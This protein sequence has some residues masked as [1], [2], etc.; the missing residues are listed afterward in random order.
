MIHRKCYE[1]HRLVVLR[2]FRGGSPTFLVPLGPGGGERD[3]PNVVPGL[4]SLD[5]PSGG[6]GLLLSD[7]VHGATGLRDEI[8]LTLCHQSLQALQHH[9]QSVMS[10]F[11]PINVGGSLKGRFF[12]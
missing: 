10:V 2:L 8:L 12:L 6:C 11:S 1:Q 4:G 7:V 9:S 3:L 5:L